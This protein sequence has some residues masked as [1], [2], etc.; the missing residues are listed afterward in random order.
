MYRQE[1]SFLTALGETRT[2]RVTGDTLLLSGPAGPVARFA[3]QSMR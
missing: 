1:N 2:W 3:A